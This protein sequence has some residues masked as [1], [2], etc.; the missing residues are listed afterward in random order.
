MPGM[1]AGRSRAA[2]DKVERILSSDKIALNQLTIN[3]SRRYSYNI[4]F[5]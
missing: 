1:G 2:P 4:H 3:A 5:M